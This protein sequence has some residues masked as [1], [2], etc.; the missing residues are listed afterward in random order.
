M[1]FL[2]VIAFTFALPACNT[3]QEQVNAC[4]PAAIAA[5]EIM[6]KQGV[7]AKVLVVRWQ[8][9][10]RNRG[11]A[12]AIFRYGKKWS[13][14]KNFGSIALT[15][16]EDTPQWEAWEANWKR[17]HKGTITEAYYLN[18]DVSASSL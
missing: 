5:R 15:S 18:H 4:L 17:G 13:Y 10:D 2:L 14:D 11:H 12:Y 16:G 7:P 3:A 1:R 8:E 6:A 9:A